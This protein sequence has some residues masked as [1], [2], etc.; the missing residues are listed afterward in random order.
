MNGD[1][2]DELGELIWA[3]VNDVAGQSSWT[4]DDLDEKYRQEY[5]R[6]I[7]EAAERHRG[8]PVADAILAASA[9]GSAVPETDDPPD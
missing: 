6:D 4:Y 9:V 5:R 2:L 7:L 1:M 3:A 8:D